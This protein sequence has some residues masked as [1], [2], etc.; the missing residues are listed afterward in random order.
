MYLG[1]L[2][3]MCTC[4][5]LPFEFHKELHNYTGISCLHC[6]LWYCQKQRS[7]ATDCFQHSV[8]A[9]PEN[10]ISTLTTGFLALRMFLHRW[11]ASI[12]FKIHRSQ[13]PKLQ[14]WRDLL[15]RYLRA[16]IRIL[17]HCSGRQQIFSL[18]RAFCRTTRLSP[19]AYEYWEQTCVLIKVDSSTHRREGDHTAEEKRELLY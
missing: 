11:E 8:A 10:I 12:E 3:L 4:F 9:E 14:Q 7:F 5:P 6:W 13:A 2:G 17:S 16:N 1:D 18:A 19:S 15:F